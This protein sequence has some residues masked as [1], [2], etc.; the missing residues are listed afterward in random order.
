MSLLTT[1]RFLIELGHNERN[2]LQPD[3]HEPLPLEGKTVLVNWVADRVGH[4]A[5]QLAKWK[6]ARVI[7]IASG[8]KRGAPSRPRRDEFIDYTKTTA[9]DVVRDV[10][11]VTDSVGD[12]TTGRFLRTLKHGGA[13]F[14]VFPLGFSG[15]EEAKKLGV[16]VSTTQV[17]SSGTQLKEVGRLLDAGTVRV[18]TDSTFP[19]AGAQK[20]HERAAHGH[21]Q[22]KMALTVA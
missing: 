3:K 7:A 8:N 12:P 22:G 19:L 15:A 6:G 14:P 20:A 21:T 13:L 17:R 16:T 9:E 4:F 18:A 2:P 10:D 1:G 11:L 5:V